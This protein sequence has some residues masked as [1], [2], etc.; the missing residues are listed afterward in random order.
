MLLWCDR[1]IECK[2]SLV[3]ALYPLLDLVHHALLFILAELID[4]ILKV[5]FLLEREE[6]LQNDR[7]Q[8][9]EIASLLLWIAP[10]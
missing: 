8:S 9:F 4:Q 10:A 2:D 1:V 6:S 7:A 5:K 3:E